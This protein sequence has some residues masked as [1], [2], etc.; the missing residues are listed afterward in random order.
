MG[1]DQRLNFIDGARGTAMFF[2]FLSHFVEK[3]LTR[4]ETPYGPLL[5][6]VA[7]IATPTFM[8]ISGLMLGYIY[9]SA[10]NF[11]NF[12]AKLIDR[13][14]FMLTA[15]HILIAFTHIPKSDSL[16]DAM[17]RW[18]FI[19][20]AIGFCILVGPFLV[21]RIKPTGRIA[22]ALLI[23]SF[24][25]LAIFYF[26]PHSWIL[27]FLKEISVG[28]LD[29]DVLYFAFPF[30]PWLGFYLINTCIGEKIAVYQRNNEPK[31][32]F[33]TFLALGS[34]FLLLVLIVKFGHKILQA[35][36]WFSFT[37]IS[38]VLV[39]PYQKLPPSPIYLF[40][41]GSMSYFILFFLFWLRDW[42]ATKEF[43]RVSSI[44]GR[45]SLFVFIIQYYVYY[46]VLW[47]LNLPY[48]PFWPIYLIGS[49]GFIVGVS[50]VWERRHLN[51]LLTLGTGRFWKNYLSNRTIRQ[52]ALRKE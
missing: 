14:L 12:R 34:T 35:N 43:V 41:F 6:T 7:M 49:A 31:K 39:S 22:F 2:V 17:Y 37:G 30:L 32:I 40:A 52:M 11:P 13:G 44:L 15:G 21:C 51:E 45:T 10:R 27:R 4:F 36:P 19:T 29:R 3:Y 1:K 26:H 25:W 38:Y 8:A 20:D 48:S 5:S 28:T 46:L 16:Q 33:R 9:Q 24:S 50:Y 47:S 18:Q 42:R 23:Y